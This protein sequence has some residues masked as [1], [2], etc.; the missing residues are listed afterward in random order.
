MLLELPI[1]EIL[2]LRLSYRTQKTAQKR[3]FSKKKGGLIR[4]MAFYVKSEL[5]M[6]D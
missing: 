5:F 1:F 2:T 6:V 4:I 3:Y